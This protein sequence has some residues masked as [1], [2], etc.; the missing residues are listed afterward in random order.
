MKLKQTKS[1]AAKEQQ[2]H[3]CN[4]QDRRT[5]QGG[6]R[7]NKN[8]VA[9][10]IAEEELE[11]CY[12]AQESGESS[13]LF[14]CILFHTKPCPLADK[15]AAWPTSVLVFSPCPLLAPGLLHL[16]CFKAYEIA[17]E[18]LRISHAPLSFF[19]IPWPPQNNCL[20]LL[21][22]DC[23]TER[24]R[25]LKLAL[26]FWH[27]D[28]FYSICGPRVMEQHRPAVDSKVR[29]IAQAVVEARKAMIQA[30]CI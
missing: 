17:L 14:A 6:Y 24:K 20:F 16:T 30:H 1:R 29:R 2:H 23:E 11:K 25:K 5:G 21:P 12:L 28:K 27:T 15:P 19:D 9:Q 13:L 8:H 18:R 3:A 4:E 26:L 22:S 10:V 7:E